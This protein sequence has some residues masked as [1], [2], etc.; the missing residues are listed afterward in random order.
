M[1]DRRI[2]Q[3]IAETD[4]AREDDPAVLLRIAENLFVESTAQGDVVHMLGIIA[5]VTQASCQFSR[6][7]LVD[8]NAA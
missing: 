1:P 8:E 3:H 7:I 4:I 6:Q 2:V 5:R